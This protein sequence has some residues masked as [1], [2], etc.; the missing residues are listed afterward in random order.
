MPMPFGWRELESLSRSRFL[1]VGCGSGQTV[2]LTKQLGWQATGLGVDPLAVR[3]ARLG[4]LDIVE[5]TF[6]QLFNFE[7][8]LDC[9]M[10]SHVLKHVHQPLQLLA[11]LHASLRPGGALLLT[12]P[13]VLSAVRQHFGVNWRGL[14]S[15]PT[16]VHPSATLSPAVCGGGW[17]CSGVAVRCAR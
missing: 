16:S 4:G 2:A 14:G 1:D 5:G 9:V 15:A 7:G 6:E 8:K 10:C 11:L 12:L 13:N 3:E 17:V